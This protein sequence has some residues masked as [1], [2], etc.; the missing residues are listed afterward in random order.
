MSGS[1][2]PAVA[3]ELVDGQIAVHVFLPSRRQSGVENLSFLVSHG[4]E[5][6]PMTRFWGMICV[7]RY[8]FARP[9][10]N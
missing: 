7:P 5:P 8:G 6:L 9:N 2:H 4:E 10:V 1:D 3:A